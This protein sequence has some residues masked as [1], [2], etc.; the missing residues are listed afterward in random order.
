MNM[1]EVEDIKKYFYKK[2]I[3]CRE[4]KE[5]VRAVDNVS[6]TVQ[7]GKTFGLVGESGCG[8]STLAKIIVGILVPDA[9]TVYVKGE[10]DIVFQDPYGSLNPRMTIFQ[11]VA[12]P[13]V[14]RKVKKR[15]IE[16]SVKEILNMVRLDYKMCKDK[17][18]HQ[19]SGGERQRIAIARALI[20]KP[21]LVVLDEP[22]SSLDV[23]IQAGILNLLKDLQESLNLTYIFISHDLRV[24][25]FMSDTVAVMKDG[26]FLETATS[27]E[28]Y[29][30]PKNVY[31]RSL[32]DSIP[33]M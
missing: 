12:E 3:F 14:V 19:F 8:K 7:K 4:K 27:D 28:I 20:H 26:K 31:T 23:S 24:V 32:L 5:P 2:G 25:E 33:K 1:I 22:V 13:L 10:K 18:P 9:G 21:D 11:I 29:R 30:S 6:F 17:Y 16:M 15:N